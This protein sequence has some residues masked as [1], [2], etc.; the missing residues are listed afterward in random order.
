MSSFYRNILDKAE[1]KHEAVVAASTSTDPNHLNDD[2][3]PSTIKEKSDAELAAELK[4]K[5]AAVDVNEEGQ[6]VDKTQLLSGGLNLGGVTSSRSDSRQS[7]SAGSRQQQGYQGRNRQQQDLRARQSKMVEDQLAQA[8][9]RALEVEEESKVEL[10][11]QSK[12][13]KTDTDVQSAKE[14]YLQRKREAAAKKLP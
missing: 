8:Q 13:R 11:R 5:G 14:R 2:K 3:A 12:S 9:K 7:Y 1:S 6:V 10:E 4:A